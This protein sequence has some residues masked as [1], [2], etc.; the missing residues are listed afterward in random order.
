MRRVDLAEHQ[1]T[2]FP[3]LTAATARA[4][5][6]TGA[7]HVSGAVGTGDIVLQAHSVVGAVP[8]GTGEDAVELHIRP[9][10]GVSRLLWM[11]GHARN[12]SGWREDEVQVGT[13]TGLV[14]AMATMFVTRC[15]RALTGGILHGYREI[16][17]TLP[18]LRGRLR[19]AD[20]MRARPGVPLPL[21]VRYDDYSIDIPENR[22][23]RTAA[24]RLL[25]IDGLAPTARMA[26]TRIV[27]DLADAAL[28]PPGPPPPT[29]S[30]TRLNR[31][32]GPALHLAQ[33]ILRRSSLEDAPGASS[34]SGF[35]FD[36][37]RVYEDWLSQA[38]MSAL[39]AIG[40][41]ARRQ[42]ALALDDDGR[43]AMQTDISWWSGTDCL[44]VIDAKYKRLQ[45]SGPRPEDV[46]QVLAYCTA[47][48]IRHGH[49]VYA[50]GTPTPAI[51]VRNAGVHIHSHVVPLTDPPDRILATIDDIA[52]KIAASAS[53]PIS[54]YLAALSDESE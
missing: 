7:V 31:R 5:Q 49:L 51:V 10:I 24:T 26:L 42:Q 53:T 15:R 38:L 34:S 28:L 30:E 46:Y 20:Q 8:A 25:A 9:K 23:L 54:R 4:L 27:R 39:D 32:Y 36:M 19:E 33:I 2:A 6:A 14:A 47:L 45:P 44:A 50:A 22:V 3:G 40:G 17:E 21:E 29:I 37:N 52:G 11:L 48:G 18:T 12:Q 1:R 16:E 35:L 13:D 41:Q 43:V